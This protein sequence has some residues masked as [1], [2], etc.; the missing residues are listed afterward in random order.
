MFLNRKTLVPARLRNPL[1]S[2]K[3]WGSANSHRVPIGNFTAMV[4]DQIEQL[5]REYTDKYVIVDAT[6]PDLRRFEGQTGVVKTINMNGNA[7][8]EF[9]AYQNIG[10]Y[11]ISLDFLKVIDQPLPKPEPKKDAPK[12]KKAA[13]AK[14]DAPAKAAKPG[15]GM[16]VADM[17]AAARAEKGGG[18]AAAPAKTEAP[19][20]EAEKPKAGGAGK[21][22]VA[23]MLAAARAEKSGGA[24]PAAEPAAAP[25]PEPEPETAPEPAP[26]AEAEEASPAGEL[27]KDVPGILDYCR[28]VDG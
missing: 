5:K 2:M 6:Q 9:D 24:A 3:I 14:K 18:G 15:G 16:S 27:P 19:Q 17:L 10:W 26:A 7:L 28:K 11:D 21:M 13:P 23:E 1:N 20:A 8:V 4:F 25:E 22:S 12:A